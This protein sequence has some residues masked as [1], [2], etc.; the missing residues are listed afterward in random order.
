MNTLKKQNLINAL[1]LIMINFLVYIGLSINYPVNNIPRFGYNSYQ[2]LLLLLLMIGFNYVFYKRKNVFTDKLN[3]SIN[4]VFSMV[5]SVFLVLGRS[6]ISRW[7]LSLIWENK[8]SIVLSILSWLAMS[9]VIY[10]L[11]N[12]VVSILQ[13]CQNDRVSNTKES[14]LRYW[15]IVFLIILILWLPYFIVSFPGLASYDGM[16]QMNE[17]FRSKSYD[18]QFVLTNHHPIFPTLIEGLFIQIG[19][20]IF[21]SINVGVLINTIFVNLISISGIATLC[22]TVKKYINARYVKYL[23]L[24]YALFPVL[25]Q[26]ANSLDKTSYFTAAF[27]YL[28]SSI[29][30]IT[31]KNI[32]RKD[33]CY[34]LLSS[35]A[36]G[37]IRN[38]GIIYIFFI[39]LGAFTLTNR[40]QVISVCISSIILILVISKCLLS[41]TNA[42]PTEPM[43]S[44]AIPIQQVY[45]V[46]KYDSQSLSK[47][48]KKKLNKYFV[49]SKMRYNYNP[50]FGDVAKYNTRWPYRKFTGSYK[51]RYRKFNTQPFVKNKHDFWKLYLQIGK[52]HKKLYTEAI[53]GLNIY[54]VYPQ[55]LPSHYGWQIGANIGNVENTHLFDAYHLTNVKYFQKSMNL[56]NKIS[57]LPIIN[58]LFITFGWFIL[59]LLTSIVIL[60]EKKYKSLSLIL[61]GLAVVLVGMISPLNGFLRYYQPL[62]VLVPV[63]VTIM[64]TKLPG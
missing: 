43:E 61:I 30:L 5:Y 21:N 37:L 8:K 4:V 15:L 48:E 56:L 28:I 55:I 19:V 40:K 45:R 26:W 64:F 22:V 32:Q 46:V 10:Y 31:F 52:K 7:N 51:D 14:T 54:Y 9:I 17:L 2:Q 63:L 24:F 1:Y 3:N 39:L 41:V 20:N 29:I 18:G 13:S 53:V 44:M 11:I 25:P 16:E 36:L 58:L 49:Y 60:N 50:E 47:S 12:F 42:L 57:E 23:V 34:L 6:Y 59:W 62:I 33:L 35:V 27:S 38:D